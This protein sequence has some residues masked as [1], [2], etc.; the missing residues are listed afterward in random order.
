MNRWLKRVVV[1][2]AIVAAVVILRLTVLRPAPVPVTV[3]KVDRGRVESTVVNSKAGTVKSRHRSEMSPGVAGMVAEIPVQK[4]QRVKQGQ[5]LLRI[6]DSEYRAQVNLAARSA[7]A[8]KAAADQAC[9]NAELSA[10]E[11]RRALELAAQR[12]IAAQ[13]V[14][15]ARTKAEADSAGCIA[16]RARDR[17]AVAS[18]EVAQ[19]TLAK[20]V[21]IAPFDGVVLDVRTDVGEWITPAPPGVVIPPV[22]DVIDPGS[23]YVEAPIDE[24]DAAKVA[25]GLTVRITLDAFRGRSFPG[26]LTYISSYVET[27]QQQNRTLTVEAEFTQGD[28]PP[29]LLPGLSADVEIILEAH[30]DVVRIP[31][32]AVL[33]G[34]RVLVVRGNRLVSVPITIGLS[35]WQ[36]TEVKS[37]LTPG[38]QVVVSLDK[39]QVKAGAR[40]RVTGEQSP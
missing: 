6:D 29:N 17:Q 25:L 22:I 9:L 35:N 40:V 13:D 34:S 30:D 32:Y 14:D 10:R 31:S 1:L 19:A 20:S 3:A 26:R 11:R 33:E 7:E 15:A 24:A 39:T 2:A 21:I 27:A 23:L 38:E 37:G 18:L 5:V 8:A 4:G 28:L 16:A 36:W 12:A